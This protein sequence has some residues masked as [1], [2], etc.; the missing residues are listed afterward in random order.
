MTSSSVLRQAALHALFHDGIWK[1]DDDFLIVIHNN[2]LSAKH[3]FQYNEILMQARY[4]VMV[5]S[6][7]GSASRDISSRILKKRPWLF[8]SDL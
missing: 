1:N 4:D 8:D 3:D 5:I 2:F 6:P 7:P